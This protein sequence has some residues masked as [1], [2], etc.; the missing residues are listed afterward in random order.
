MRRR[1]WRYILTIIGSGGA[2]QRWFLLRRCWRSIQWWRRLRHISRSLLDGGSDSDNLPWRNGR[3]LNNGFC[4]C[5]IIIIQRWWFAAVFIVVSIAIGWHYF[6]FVWVVSSLLTAAAAMEMTRYYY[7]Y[8]NLT[9]AA[10]TSV[11]H[12]NFYKHEHR[13]LLK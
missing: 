7:L 3:I 4:V 1:W 6:V 11:V 10:Q 13:C 8:N 5:Q 9:T 12:D 2:M